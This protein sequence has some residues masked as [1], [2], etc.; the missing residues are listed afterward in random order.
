MLVYYFVPFIV[1]NRYLLFWVS[2]G[3]N[4]IN[5]QNQTHVYMNFSDHKDLGNHLLQLCPKVMKHPVFCSTSNCASNDSSISTNILEMLVN[6]PNTLPPLPSKTLWKHFVYNKLIVRSDDIFITDYTHDI[7]WK[8]LELYYLR[9][10]KNTVCCLLIRR[11]D[12]WGLFTKDVTICWLFKT[13]QQ[14]A[15]N[16]ELCLA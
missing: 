8:I 13:A 1:S 9:W 12:F 3:H 2:N 4:S 11:T 15:D 7:W 10:L 6:I 14:L 16:L 5:V